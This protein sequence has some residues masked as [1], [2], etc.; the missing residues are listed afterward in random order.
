MGIPIPEPVAEVEETKDEEHFVGKRK[1][2]LASPA[3]EDESEEPDLVIF[4][5]N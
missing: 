3:S 4:T 2:K 1:I 5:K